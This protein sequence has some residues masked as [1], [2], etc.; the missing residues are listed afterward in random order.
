MFLGRAVRVRRG[1]S[2]WAGIDRREMGAG[3][4]TSAKETMKEHA[5]KRCHFLF[6]SCVYF[7]HLFSIYFSSL[8]LHPRKQVLATIS[9]DRSWK[10]WAV[11]RYV[12][13]VKITCR[14]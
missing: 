13:A 10:M 7:F 9:D 2:V 5:F 6:I 11:P 3:L 14:V 1:V 8:A 4:I 12:L